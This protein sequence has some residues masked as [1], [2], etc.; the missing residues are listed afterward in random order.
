MKRYGILLAVLSLCLMTSCAVCAA[1]TLTLP[2]TLT[3]IV[4]N[5]FSKCGLTSLTLPAGVR[6]IGYGAMMSCP[7][8]ET[9]VFP[10]GLERIDMVLVRCPMLKRVY[11]P[12][13]VTFIDDDNLYVNCGDAAVVT[14]RGSYAWNW[15]TGW[16]IPVQEP[17]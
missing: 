12:A 3:E 7:N 14:P 1:E 15:A 11:I 5:A 4:Q 13:S 16:G 9:V 8:L 10:E 17:D 6:S 2:D